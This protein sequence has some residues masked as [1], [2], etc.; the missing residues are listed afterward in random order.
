MTDPQPSAETRTVAVAD[1]LSVGWPIVGAPGDLTGEAIWVQI[2]GGHFTGGTGARRSHGG[3]SS[4]GR[5]G[6]PQ[7]RH[8]PRDRGGREEGDPEES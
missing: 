3:D 2:P 4:P 5:Q 8:V 7:V 6:A 1:E